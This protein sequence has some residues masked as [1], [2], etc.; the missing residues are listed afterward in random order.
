[1]DLCMGGELFN[2]IIQ[3]YHTPNTNK[4]SGY[5]TEADASLIIKTVL[6]A[7]QYLHS[8]GIVHRD[9]KPENILFRNSNLDS[10]VLSIYTHY[11]HL[12][13]S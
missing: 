7:V 6:N 10:L 9:I 4:L 12:Y 13:H 8:N 3:R 5:F 11:I 2:H 1:M